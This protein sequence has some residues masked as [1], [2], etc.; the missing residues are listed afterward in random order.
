MNYS[1]S[2]PCQHLVELMQFRL[3]VRW[4]RVTT[5][6]WEH[7]ENGATL[8]RHLRVC[9]K[10]VEGAVEDERH[11]LLE[12]PA[13]ASV[14][15]RFSDLYDGSDGDMAQVMCH[16]NQRRVALLVHCLKSWRETDGIGVFLEDNHLDGF[17]SDVDAQ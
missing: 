8:P 5:G 2:I 9:C 10:C 6:W 13:Y 16:P 14:R 15:A 3:G 7:G 17:E 11:V 4:L 12:C 1:G